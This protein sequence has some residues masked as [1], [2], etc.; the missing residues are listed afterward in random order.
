MQEFYEFTPD[1]EN[2]LT[3]KEDLN[4]KTIIVGAGSG[5][6]V[7]ASRLSESPNEEVILIEAGPDYPE[8]ESTPADIRD[9]GEMSVSAHD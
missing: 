4:G 7:L 2:P 9:A 1:A 6:G 5:G 8:F 3:I